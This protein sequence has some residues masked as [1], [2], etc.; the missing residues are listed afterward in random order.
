M[1]MGF[2]LSEWAVL[3]CI[4]PFWPIRSKRACGW[5]RPNSC[6]RGGTR[7]WWADSLAVSE[8]QDVTR[9]SYG[10]C[11]DGWICE[12][13]PDLPWPLDQCPGPAMPCD[14][15]ACPYRIEPRPVKK[16]TGFAVYGAGPV[17]DIE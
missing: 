12:R 11:D 1:G 17:A 6:R 9:L 14:V 16:T 7:H 8:A 15:A 5:D 13:H 4:R 3:D 10:K 2:R